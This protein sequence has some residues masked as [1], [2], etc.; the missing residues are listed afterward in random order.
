MTTKTITAKNGWIKLE[1]NGQIIR[2]NSVEIHGPSSVSLSEDGLL[3]ISTESILTSKRDF[4]YI[5]RIV[6]PETGQEN[7][8]D[9]NE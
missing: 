7:K 2:A 1:I 8:K 4:P 3:K 5:E 6:S 9:N